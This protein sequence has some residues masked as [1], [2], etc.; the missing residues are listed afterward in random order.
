MKIPTWLIIG[1]AAIAAW[2]YAGL[3]KAAALAQIVFTGITINSLTDYTATFTIQNVTNSTIVVNSLAGT[4]MANGVNIANISLFPVQPIQ[5]PGN[6]QHDVNVDV[7]PNLI[8]L[9]SAILAALQAG[10]VPISFEAQGAAN[11]NNISVPF[12]VTESFA[13]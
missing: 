2:Y 13:V 7:K 3:A 6:S 4:L 8:N 11:V 12:D 9:P 1:G 5:I 10:N